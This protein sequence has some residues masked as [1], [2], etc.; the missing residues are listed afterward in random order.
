[1][2]AKKKKRTDV[3][4]LVKRY[5][6][7]SVVNEI[8]ANL[9][10]VSRFNVTPDKLFLCPLFNRSNYDLSRYN[11]LKE[12]LKKDG[13]LVP[14]VVVE[15]KQKGYEIINGVKRFLIGKEIGLKEIPII[16]VDLSQERKFSYIL[17]NIQYENDS[18]YVKTYAFQKLKTQYNYSEEQIAQAAMISVS[19]VKNLLR[20][21]N[22]PDFL[23]Q[24][25]IS[26]NLTYGEARTLL[27]LPLDIQKRLFDDI[28]NGT[29][30]VR[31]LEKAKRNYL[32]NE[33]KTTVSLKGKTVVIH[34]ESE[35]DA[36]KNFIKIQRDYKD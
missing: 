4:S 24:A 36:K 8:E 16:K 28:Q 10:N 15:N 23:K 21:E 14:L 33:R 19:Q 7:L 27:N 29:I 25:L 2:S 34:F 30:S 12:S 31:D 3:S 5:Q 1:M 13:F 17:E 9:S 26:F 20:L 32:G 11:T 18:P 35:E 22:L 6:R